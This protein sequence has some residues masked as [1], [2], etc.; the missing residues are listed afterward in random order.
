MKKTFVRKVAQVTRVRAPIGGSY[1]IELEC[2]H[3][4][5]R[6]FS[7]VKGIIPEFLR[8]KTCEENYTNGL[9]RSGR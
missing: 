5:A 6:K 8:C 1:L 7:Q 9:L 2:G 3:F 4:L